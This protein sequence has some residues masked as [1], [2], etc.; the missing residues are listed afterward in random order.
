MK[1]LILTQKIDINDDVLGFM[2]GW[3]AEFAKQCES[4]T[5]ICLE[6]G[7]YDL[8]DNVKVLSLG[9][10]RA[11]KKSKVY[12]VESKLRYIFNFYK[13]IWQ[14]RK[15]YDSVFVHMNQIY[16]VL[17]GVFWRIWK[18]KIGLWYAHGAV[19]PSLKL[20][21]F[22]TNFVFT[23][24]ESGFRLK[25]KKKKVVGQ[26]IPDQKLIE[27]KSHKTDEKFRIVSVGRMSISK[28]YKTLILASEI[29]KNKNINF[30]VQILG[31]PLTEE[32]EVYFKSIK[33]LV[34]EKQLE[35][36]VEFLGS[37]AYKNISNY[38]NQA[39]VFVNMGKTGS[40]DK[41]ILE[42]MAHELPVLTCNEA[43]LEIWGSYTK[44]L[45]YSKDSYEELAKK[46][47]WVYNL[48][49]KEREKIGED[50]R[51]IVE[52]DHSL[53]QLIIKIL[54]FYERLSV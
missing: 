36:Y 49:K 17:G 50:L 54:G 45:M 37:V 13:Y 51:K 12:K 5:V 22:M 35:S 32:D 1:L 39:D 28:D 25:S 8:P 10:E 2:H 16:V 40:L 14:E 24:T 7:S 43:V 46:I 29:L 9:K 42:A 48:E 3:V 11:S 26:G 20:A 47:E 30:K 18:K 19:S 23:S 52:K 4:L 6:K 27:S 44:K 21:H 53:S 31:G 34:K 41:V 15:N 33:A 38:L